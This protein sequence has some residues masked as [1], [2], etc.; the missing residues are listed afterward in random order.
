ML[1]R[2]QY[3]DFHI[4]LTLPR[5]YISEYRYIHFVFYRQSDSST[6]DND[7]FEYADVKETFIDG[8][9]FDLCSTKEFI[10]W[11]RGNYARVFAFEPE[12]S[13]YEFCKEKAE[14]LDNVSLLL[15]NVFWLM[16]NTDRQFRFLLCNNM[17][18]SQ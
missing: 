7:F 9:A 13:D 17:S 15:N 16:V 5:M 8:G 12:K 3:F 1:Y 4:G 10:K 11:C 6:M 18:C 14:H 2:K